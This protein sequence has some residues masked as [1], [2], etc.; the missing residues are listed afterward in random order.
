MDFSKVKDLL[1]DFGNGYV[2]ACLHAC[3]WNPEAVVNHLLEGSPPPSVAH[4]DPG[5]KAWSPPAP[6]AAP[7]PLA[8]SA[9]AAAGATAGGGSGRGRN[10]GAG[11]GAPGMS[12]TGLASEASSGA[13]AAAAAATAAAPRPGVGGP[14][15]APPRKVDKRTARL[16]GNVSDDVRVRAGH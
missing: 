1:P 16:L 5:L 14:A 15:A 11:I 7:P 10:G 2:A 13:A 3:S 12:W 8:R 4:L 9:A 6:A